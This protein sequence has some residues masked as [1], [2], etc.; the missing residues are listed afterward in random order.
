MRLLRSCLLALMVLPLAASAQAL[1]KWV[2]K[3]GKVHYSDQPPPQ[4]A[5]KVEQPRLRGGSID[6]SGLPYETQQAAKN[7]PVTLYTSAECQESCE[8][9]RAFLRRRGVPFSESVLATE[10]Q[11]DAHKRLFGAENV[12]LPAISVGRQRQQGFEEGAWNG[13]LDAAGYARAAPS[14]AR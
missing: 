7:F 4:E 11:F 2:G 12:F 6:T 14:A 8:R 9:A 1:Y 3:D 13:L 5:R 10:E